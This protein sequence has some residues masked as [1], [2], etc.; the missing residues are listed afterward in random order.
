MLSQG[1]YAEVQRCASQT[2][3]W[4]KQYLQSGGSLLGIALDNLSLGRAHLLQ[5]QRDSNHPSATLRTGSITESANYLNRAV[6]GLRQAGQQQYIPLG[7][8]ARAEFHRVT[9]SLDR[10]KRDLDEAFSIATRGG[11]RLFVADCHLEYAR[12]AVARARGRDVPP[13]RLYNDDA[14]EHLAI[15]KKMID[16]MGYHRRDKEVEE[17]EAQ[18]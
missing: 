3:E 18:V 14:R 15:A 9:A 1:D 8:L 7:L 6:D 16:E 12:L 5:S 4:A 2:L 13:E 11:M 10:A 17:L